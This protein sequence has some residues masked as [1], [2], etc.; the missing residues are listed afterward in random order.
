M[1]FAQN[2][3]PEFSPHPLTF[4]Q[5]CL[6]QPRLDARTAGR[7]TRSGRSCG[8]ASLEARPPC[9]APTLGWPPS[10]SGTASVP[11]ASS[12][13][14]GWCL[15]LTASPTGG[16]WPALRSLH[17]GNP[18][19]SHPSITPPLVYPPSRPPGCPWPTQPSQAPYPGPSGD[20]FTCSLS[21]APQPQP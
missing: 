1:T 10:T 18:H 5:P 13:P 14:A 19:R 6:S 11:G 16:S 21:P 3:W 4:W 2:T 9:R 12:T 15:R 7:D 8:P 17:P 20:H